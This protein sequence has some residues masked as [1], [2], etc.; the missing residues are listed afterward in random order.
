MGVVGEYSADFLGQLER[1]FKVAGAKNLFSSKNLPKRL[2]RLWMVLLAVLCFAFTGT[3]AQE[4]V[5]SVTA[6]AIILHAKIY[7]LNAK[8]PWADELRRKGELTLRSYVAYSLNPP[9]L[10][11][12]DLEKIGGSTADV[13][14]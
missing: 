1:S 5:R 11:A 10:R 9:E 7:T 14:R 3:A 6:D 8:Q 12:E 13:P 4:K 2:L